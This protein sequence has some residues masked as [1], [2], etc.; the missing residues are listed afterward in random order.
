MV[1]NPLYR[2]WNGKCKIG[3]SNLYPNMSSDMTCPAVIPCWNTP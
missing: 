1:Y 2:A 3:I